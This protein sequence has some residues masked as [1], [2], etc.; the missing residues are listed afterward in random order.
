MLLGGDEMGRTQEGN[1]NAYCQDNELSWFDWSLVEK[2]QDLVDLVSWLAQLRREHPV[3]RHR[4]WFVGSV[5]ADPAAADIAWFAPTGAQM[6]DGDWHG[7]GRSVGLFLNGDGVHTRGSMGEEIVDDSFLMFF[8]ADP[9]DVAFKV[10]D[11][12]WGLRW[13]QLLDTRHPKPEGEDGP[14]YGP[15][16][17]VSLVP[18]SVVVLRRVR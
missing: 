6:G 17:A 3:F 8:N 10:P 11:Q 14:G 5:A 4:R 12:E 9:D 18:R 16:D 2:N 7:D 1:N 15:G 13:R